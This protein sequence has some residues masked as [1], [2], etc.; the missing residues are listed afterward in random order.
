M[1]PDLQE[2]HLPFN[3][4]PLSKYLAILTLLLKASISKQSTKKNLKVEIE[5]I[6]KTDG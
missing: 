2:G 5:A 3:Y 4:S 6:S 1:Q